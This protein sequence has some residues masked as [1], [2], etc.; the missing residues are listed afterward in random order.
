MNVMDL[1]S[2]HTPFSLI[3]MGIGLVGIT[4]VCLVLRDKQAYC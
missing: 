3:M 4:I 1:I 2:L